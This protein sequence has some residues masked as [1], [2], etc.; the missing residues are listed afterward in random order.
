MSAMS[1][2][3]EPLLFPPEKR[4]PLSVI[5]PGFL[6]LSV[7]GHFSAFFI[8]QVVYPQRVTIP[9]P[10]PQVTCRRQHG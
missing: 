8:F 4:R 6:A 2:R 1:Q 9:M 7:I 10:A 5:L 3:P